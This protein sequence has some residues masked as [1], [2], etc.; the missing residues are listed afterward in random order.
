MLGSK[1]TTIDDLGHNVPVVQASQLL[2]GHADL[3]GAPAV[4][5]F[6]KRVVRAESHRTR[7]R[8]IPF[9]VGGVL[10]VMLAA[11]SIRR[12]LPGLPFYAPTIVFFVGI[13]FLSAG[14]RFLTMRTRAPILSATATSFGL[15]GSCG[16]TLRGLAPN[17]RGDLVCPECGSAWH[18][19]RV[20]RPHWDAAGRDGPR[21][22]SW[23]L[24]CIGL[25]PNEVHRLGADSRGACFLMLDKRLR[26]LPAT[27]RAELGVRRV[28]QLRRTLCRVGA[29]RR[30]LFALLPILLI[31]LE[32]V[33]FVLPQGGSDK[34]AVYVLLAVTGLSLL[35][36]GIAL[37]R[38][39]TG[40]PPAARGAAAARINI[41]N[42]C[43]RDLLTDGIPQ[44]D[45]TVVCRG[46]GA[47]WP[48]H[49]TPTPGANDAPPLPRTMPGDPPNRP[50]A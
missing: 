28:H 18:H 9:A 11:S 31:C 2:R 21:H 4:G 23:F 36:G 14:M 8:T 16:Y 30:W 17:D 38:G 50:V 46:C 42:V 44:P 43:A 45:H 10:L 47:A 40:A 1:P 6:L 32:I 20:T 3:E 29:R 19:F 25:L 5:S 26:L 13:G 27:R 35:F 15:C 33:Y 12:F 7:W 49:A 37:I 24:R 39:Y 41:C 22:R 48:A 34:V